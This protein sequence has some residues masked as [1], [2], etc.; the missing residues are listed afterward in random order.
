MGETTSSLNPSLAVNDSTAALN[1]L[2]RPL[3]SSGAGERRSPSPRLVIH[4]APSLSKRI[5]WEPT[6]T[7]VSSGGS[8]LSDRGMGRTDLVVLAIHNFPLAA[9][10][11]LVTLPTRIPV[12]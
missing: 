5:P 7:S 6:W 2:I 9:C 4:K 10:A 1:S 11:I 3:S 8:R 12:G